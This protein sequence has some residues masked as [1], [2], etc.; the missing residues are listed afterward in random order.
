MTHSLKKG[1]EMEQKTYKIQD[2]TL[3]QGELS[4]ND[5]KKMFAL[6]KGIDWGQFKNAKANTYEI[7]SN[8]L[9][10]GTLELLIDVI[11]KGEKPKGEAGDWLTASLTMEV[12]TDFFGLNTSLMSN[13]SSFL[14]NLTQLH[15]QAVTPKEAQK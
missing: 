7:V 1:K 2:K 14:S 6:L 11:L 9:D 10:E 5:S 12:V 13:V 15:S 3:T 8:F 4:L